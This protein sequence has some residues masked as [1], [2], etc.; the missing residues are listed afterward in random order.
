MTVAVVTD[1]TGYLP[2]ELVR[3][4]GVQVVPL[5][6][7]WGQRCGLDA[8]DVGPAEVARAL[9]DPLTPVTTSRPSPVEFAARYRELLDN[10][11]DEVVSVHLS[12]LLS[13]TWEAA[14]IAADEVGPSRIRVVDSGSAGMGLGFAVLACARAAMAG[15]DGGS[16]EAEAVRVAARS[17]VFFCVDSLEHLRR[18]G[19]IGGAAAWLGNALSVK[20]LLRVSGGRLEPLAKVR[21]AGRACALMLDLAVAAAGIGAA[22]V[23][24]HHLGAAERAGELVARLAER[25]PAARPAVVCEVGAVIGAHVGPG[26]LGVVVVPGS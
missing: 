22:R 7:Q 15:A 1:S 4:H 10:G 13:G 12:R 18:G 26:L 2:T 8:V 9:A 14:R 17:R 23:A 6:V 19:R 11:A 24:V 3:E 25:L 5:R 20:P 16:V 21:T